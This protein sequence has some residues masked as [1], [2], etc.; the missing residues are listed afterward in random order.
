L[1]ALGLRRKIIA[2]NWKMNKG[3]SESVQLG[4]DVAAQAE[5]YSSAVDI[6][7]CPTFLALADV[8][9]AIAGTSTRTGA[10]DCYHSKQGAFTGEVNPELIKD[11]GASYCIIGHSERRTLM[12]ESDK[13]VNLKAKAML[14]EGLIPIICVGETLEEKQAGDTI[15]VVS[16]QTIRAYA[17]ISAEDAAHTVIA[18]EPIW[19]IGT[20]LNATPEDAQTVCKAI[21][22]SLK[23][24]L[25]G[26]VAEGIRIQYG[27]SVKSDNIE[28]FMTQHDIDGA[29]VG[30][31][32]LK[33]DE[34]ARIVAAA[35]AR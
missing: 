9:R 3:I 29:L 4:V 21:R 23:F 17:G 10:Q 27:G 12:G 34:F 11:A 8:S 15:N 1:E 30:G 14:K 19:A 16:A 2:G 18:Y 32:S 6:V 35:A 22:E 7:I 13:A 28:G 33:A 31:A 25:G 20:G 24:I 5:R 26:K